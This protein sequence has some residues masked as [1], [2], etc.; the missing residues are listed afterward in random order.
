MSKRDVAELACRILAFTILALGIY[1]ILFVPL[2]VVAGLW[3]L[4]RG[5]PGSGMGVSLLI[6]SVSSVLTLALVC[7]L[8]T[9]TEWVARKLVPDDGRNSRWPHIRVVDLQTAAFST[10]GVVAV[11]MGVGALCRS[12]GLYLG[13]T[14]LTGRAR[15]LGKSTLPPG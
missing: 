7:F 3:D 1:E 11:L 15:A 14:R 13:Q 2:A 5:G 8:W 4:M 6:G 9:R 10:V 12:L